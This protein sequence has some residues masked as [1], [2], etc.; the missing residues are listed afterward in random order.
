VR[1]DCLEETEPAFAALDE[2]LTVG[3]PE[4][5]EIVVRTLALVAVNALLDSVVLPMDPETCVVAERS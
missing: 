1:T 2:E 3:A 5:N 4:F